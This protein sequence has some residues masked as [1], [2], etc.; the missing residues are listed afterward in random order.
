MFGLVIETVG[1][2]RDKK[3]HSEM[4]NRVYSALL[5]WAQWCLLQRLRAR[6]LF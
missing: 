5:M 1:A 3:W 4:Q 2:E 6:A